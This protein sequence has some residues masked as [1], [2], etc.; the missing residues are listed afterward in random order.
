MGVLVVI[1]LVAIAELYVMVQVA[2][3]IGALSTIALL[4]L[5]SVSGPWLVRRTGLGVWRRARTRVDQGEM[6]GRE[7]VDGVL[8][9]G[10][11]V[12]LT[13]P[14]FI[15]GVLGL[16][17]LLPPIRALVRMIGGRWAARRVT[18]RTWGGPGPG[19]HD[20]E[21]ITTTSRPVDETGRDRQGER[22]AVGPGGAPPS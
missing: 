7:I 8:L 12:L 2:H 9:L 20:G 4:V 16:L 5:F 15:T 13:V 6:P 21:V 1:V 17:L 3:H 18:V 19:W 11:G 14:G 22:P 10:A